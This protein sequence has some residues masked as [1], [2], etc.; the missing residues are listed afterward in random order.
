MPNKMLIDASHPEETRVV[1]VRGNRIE[2]FDFESQ[3]KKQ[4][5]GNIYL[6][7]V[8]RVEPS[9]QAAF[10]EYGGN[11]HGFL[12]FSEIHPDY[13]QIPVADRQA[14]LRA[15][16]QEAE[17]EDDEEAEGGE[18]QQARDRG[19]RSR[20]RGGK[21]RDRGE[22]KRGADAAGSGESS[23]GGEEIAASG[24]A[25]G[26][27]GDA[28]ASTENVEAMSETDDSVTEAAA[29]QENKAPEASVDAT[30]G[31]AEHEDDQ[32]SE[33][34]P[35]SIAASVDADVI[36]EA[37]P[38]AESASEAA[39]ADEAAP[40]DSD[41]G[42]LEEVQSAHSDEHEIESVGAED[43]LEEVRNRRKPVRRQY[44]IQEV[45]KRR[46]ILLV[47][48]VK[49]ERGNKGAALTTY[50]S[51]A[52]RYS[53]LMPNTARGGGISRK[54]TNAQDRK[55]LKEV[56]ADLE[57]PQ[58]M[59][60]ILRT[61]GES[62]TKAEIK[63]D[64]EYLMRLWENVRNLTL[65][66]SAPALVYEEG[67][68]IKRSVRDLYNKDIDEI[69]VS[70]EDGYREAKDF[71]RMLMPSHAKVVQPYRDATPIFVRN[72]IEAQ[73]DRM[74]QP[75]VTLK[76]GGY[77]II[78]QTEALVSIDVNSGRSTKEH[79]IE[80][81]ALHTNLEAAEE[82]ARQL[83][84]RDLAGLIVIDFI[85]MEENRNNRS[86]EKRLKDHLKND[87]ARIQVGRIS[88]FGLMEM[89]RQRIRASVLESTMKPCPHCGGT[90]H[91]RSDSSVA[92][93][94]VR[95][96]EEFLLKDSRSHIIVRTPAATA[97]YVLNHK[98]ANLVE[99]EARFGLTITL[100]ADETLGSQHYAIFRGAVAE[101]PEGF[102]EM[103]SLPTY[104]EPE[105]PE[106]EIVVEEEDEVSGQAEQPRHPQ[107][108]QHPQ[109]SEDGEGRKRRKRRR[110]RGG[111]DRDR[112]HGAP[113]DAVSAPAPADAAAQESEATPE[114]KA[115]APADAEATLEASEDGA[116]KKRRRGKR[117]GKRNR[118]EDDEAVA[119]A[120]GEAE[121][122]L[123]RGQAEGEAPES[124]PAAAAEGQPAP[125]NDDAPDAE[126]PKKPR[127]ASRAKKA[128]QEAVVETAPTP[129]AELPAEPVV[130]EPAVAAAASA[131]TEAEA[132][133]NAHP[134]RRKPQSIDAPVVPI[135]SSTVTDE[136][137]AEEKPKR[138]GW[139]QRKGFF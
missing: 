45:I 69:L 82:V 90:G 51:L 122:G 63:R 55:R 61:A 59:G 8:T 11:R 134:T 53:V 17:D 12:A 20:R 99:L 58:G 128:A 36:S 32:P 73:L 14:L 67:S 40:S 120:A 139:W 100:E 1:V 125:A 80:D 101:K 106:D 48:V 132:P 5:K 78:N 81:T 111:K 97:L 38:Q 113:G 16:A 86:V 44:K 130:A 62:R 26:D 93:M 9:L 126:K 60:V 103:R 114:L 133:A 76:S 2:E 108:G 109:R 13:Y 34:G 56:V 7:R 118:R 28:D 138:A 27:A 127:R 105:E 33:G 104:V 70:G 49:E 18:E 117:G 64:Y 72:G 85:D 46:Q 43:A 35:T 131:A 39:P 66:S 96:I 50:L 88:H 47:Q 89:S 30:E 112:E 41:R 75:Q 102:V 6:A 116:G 23:E 74:L 83:R 94:V 52:G 137:K 42:M 54:I 95:A 22:H 3:D 31:K 77:I 29:E 24:E 110:R 87:R 37:V 136:A 129:P 4:L 92:L 124:A 19:R 115:D 65:Q 98:R 91:V 57:V 123:E 15:E 119:D 25:G 84:L 79:S 121:D 68:L 135:V 21:N 10:V 71:M 107:Q